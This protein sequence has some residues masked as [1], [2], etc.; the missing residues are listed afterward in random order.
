MKLRCIRR[1]EFLSLSKKNS[2]YVYYVRHGSVTKKANNEDE[3]RLFELTAKIP[4]DDRINHNAEIEDIDKELIK[5]FLRTVKSSLY[6]E[7]D[8]MDLLDLCERMN[9][10]RGPKEYKKPVNVGLLFFNK[11]PDNFFKGAKIE[12][13]IYHDDVGDSLSEKI[14]TGPVYKQL[15]NALDYIKSN[16]L[17]E[18][19]RKIP[20]Q[21]E[22]ERFFNYPY[23]A[24]E[25][26]LT[27]A[28]YH[29]SYELQ[30]TIE[31]NIRLDR[32]EILSYPGPL[33]PINNK[34]LKK[35]HIIARD[36]RNRRIGDFLKEL[37]FTEGRGTGIPKIRRAM[38]Q[39]NS[40]DPIFETDDNRYY[41]LV[42]L[43]IHP[44]VTPQVTPQ[45]KKI[46]KFCL[47]PKKRDTIQKEVGLSDREYFRKN[48]LKPLI[49]EG[50]LRRTAKPN[51]PNLKY[52]TTEKGKQALG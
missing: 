37:K 18:E 16:I 47:I 23:E 34:M 28:V 1:W 9:I 44:Q 12:V 6:D 33:P 42:I 7:V 26:A 30:N 24:I 40:P 20:G 31:V 11:T 19:V 50:L 5:D 51:S 32:I 13:V 29:R 36:Y 14:F 49:E 48:I 43:P 41:F 10:I 21:A 17:I 45:V 15:T 22:A 46:L 27:N 3:R 52:V 25:E 35:E 4:F 38:K 39:N 2:N 8:K